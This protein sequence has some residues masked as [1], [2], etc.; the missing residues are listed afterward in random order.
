MD[1]YVTLQIE[2]TATQ[3]EIKKAY[4]KLA[5]LHHPDKGGNPEEFKK[6]S[7]A[8]LVLSD[9]NR[10]ME[11]D[12][13]MPS[14]LN[15]LI[16]SQFFKQKA[17]KQK[18]SDLQVKVAISLFEVLNGTTKKIK[19][20]RKTTCKSCVKNVSFCK[21]CNGSGM[22][23]NIQNMGGFHQVF[24]SNCGDCISGSVLIENCGDCSNK[25]VVS[26]NVEIS[27]DLPK[28]L[29]DGN[30]IVLSGLGNE[31]HNRNSG[32]VLLVITVTPHSLFE[33]IGDF[34]LKI[35]LNVSIHEALFGCVKEL[36][37]L[38]G[39]KIKI[40]ISAVIKPNSTKT[41]Q[42]RGL[43]K[44]ENERGDLNIVFNVVFPEK[45]PDKCLCLNSVY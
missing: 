35:Q 36:V 5:L 34:D 16:F 17:P 31:A 2:K 6:I 13:P 33:R 38:E 28:N 14:N 42:G 32:D 4:K 23:Q 44:H 25:M 20:T 39:K 9:E 41:L 30:V 11:Y 1:Y 43:F 37:L 15:D 8:Y 27:V 45:S 10:R 22:K 18:C 7:E 40:K 24:M 12:N 26:E 21:T 29:R 19:I 3:K